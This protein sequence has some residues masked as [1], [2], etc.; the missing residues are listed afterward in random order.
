MKYYARRCDVTSQGMNEGWCWGDG[1]FYT[2]YET[3]TIKE[4]RKDFPEKKDMTNKQLLEWAVETEDLLYWTEW[5]E[6][7]D[8]QW[9]KD[10]KGN[11]HEAEYCYDTKKPQ[12][13]SE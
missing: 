4:L 7:E 6:I 8:T 2:K 11:W 10:S 5:P 1:V 12:V 3:D 13:V 9:A